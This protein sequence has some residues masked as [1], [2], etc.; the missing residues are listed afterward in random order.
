[1]LG[2]P[3]A[4]PREGG[5]R[6]VVLHV[7]WLSSPPQSPVLLTVIFNSTDSCP[8]AV[9]SLSPQMTILSACLKRG[10]SLARRAICLPCQSS[11]CGISSCAR[12]LLPRLPISGV[13][14]PFLCKTRT[15]PLCAGLLSP[16]LRGIKLS[17]PTWIFNLPSDFF[18]VCLLS[19]L[20]KPRSIIKTNKQELSSILHPPPQILPSF[21]CAPFQPRLINLHF[22]P[23]LPI[24]AILSN[25][26]SIH[27]AAVSPD[28]VI[29]FVLISPALGKA[30]GTAGHLLLGPGPFLPSPGPTP[31]SCGRSPL[32][33]CSVSHCAPNCRSYHPNHLPSQTLVSTTRYKSPAQLSHP[34]YD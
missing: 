31:S 8:Q 16:H 7:S 24:P 1:M 33:A 18:W 6:P 19:I 26:V 22:E 2:P 30:S 21:N 10:R 13:R 11:V 20:L 3:P 34:K 17:P 12:P 14:A 5:S 23:L 25:L 32:S 29:R 4:Q 9:P 27:R 28:P 15:P